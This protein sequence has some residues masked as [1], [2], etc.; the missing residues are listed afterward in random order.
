MNQALSDEIQTVIMDSICHSAR[1]AF[2]AMAEDF[3]QAAAIFRPKIFI[4]GNQW[5]AL[6]GDNIQDGVAGFGA[7][8]ME[9]M[10][11]FN[12]EWWTKLPPTP[13]PAHQEP[14]N[15]TASPAEPLQGAHAPPT[16]GDA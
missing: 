8:P 9:A 13:T 16:N 10:C 15:P 12:K 1:Q 14:T 6:Y 2:S 7:S 4:D 5:C 11:A 3:G